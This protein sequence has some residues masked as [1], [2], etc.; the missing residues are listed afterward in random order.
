MTKRRIILLIVILALILSFILPAVINR[1][2]FE[3]K[4]KVYVAA[5]DATRLETF[6]EEDELYDVLLKYKNAGATTALIHEKQGKYNEAT[7]IAAKSAGLNLALAPDVTF[8]ED[9]NLEYFVRTYGVKYIKLEKGIWGKLYES[10][11]KSDPVCKVIDQYD[12][13]L[14]ISENIMQLGN[15]EPRHFDDYIEAADGKIIRNYTSYFSTNVD[16]K[17]Y[18]AVY[19]QMYNSAYDR[20]TRF[21]TVKQLLDGGFTNEQNAE[22]TM[23]NVRLFCDKMESLG[24]TCEGE[25][26]YN[27]YRSDL[28]TVNAATAAIT[29]LLVALIL[30]LLLKFK[31]PYL[32]IISVAVAGAAFGLTY[33]MPEWILQLYPTVFASVAPC[34]SIAALLV[35]IKNAKEKLSFTKLLL[36]SLGITLGM[37]AVF[38]GMMT[39]LLGSAEY[40]LN[41]LHFRGVKATL[42]LP[43][44][45]AGLILLAWSY[46]KRT[47]SEYKEWALSLIKGLRWY[48]FLLVGVAAIIIII[49][50]TRSGNVNHI[51]FFET[52]FRNWLTE[53]FAARPRTKDFLLAWPCLALYV[54][55]VKSNK[56][57]IF[58]WAFGIGTG[59]LFSSAIN[60]FCH[61]FTLTETMYL[62]IA[63]GLLFGIITAILYLGINHLILKLIER[64]KSKKA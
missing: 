63:T 8:P 4:S 53:V 26:N 59:L 21:I 64:I 60:T 54:Y 56:Y 39:A 18:P 45:F 41:T 7:I 19:Y 55:Y 42:I 24:Y 30:D 3:Q 15:E 52:N 31:I 33:L 38:G 6:F 27:D 46:K 10:Y 44:L 20:N 40:F 47:L 48:H 25:I 23:K 13:T 57:P 35:Y 2:G 58:Q 5:I 51:S 61:A 17:D 29:V 12:L 62:R 34:F 14:V 9:A 16:Q 43:L 49:Y 50:I 22:R 1:V 11:G 28:K 37:I 32:G 36:S